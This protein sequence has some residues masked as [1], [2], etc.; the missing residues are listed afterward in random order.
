MT[1]LEAIPWSAL[2][3][4]DPAPRKISRAWLC[5]HA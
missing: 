5:E 1:D 3:G 2:L 4:E